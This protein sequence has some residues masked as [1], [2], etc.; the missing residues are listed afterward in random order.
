MAACIFLLKWGNH[1]LPGPGGKLKPNTT[2]MISFDQN[3]F[4]NKKKYFKAFFI[5][6]DFLNLFFIFI[7]T[8]HINNCGIE[9]SGSSQGS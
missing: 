8:G 7:K 1:L 5:L 9:Q 3:W 6:L 2:G 4:N